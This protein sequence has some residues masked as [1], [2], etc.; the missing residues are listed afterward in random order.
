MALV[1]WNA[2]VVAE[3]G[4]S[5]IAPAEEAGAVEETEEEVRDRQILEVKI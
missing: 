1:L 2:L 5:V 3:E 4:E